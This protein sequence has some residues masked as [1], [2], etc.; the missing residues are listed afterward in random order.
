[1]ETETPEECPECESD[2]LV[3]EGRRIDGVLS[4]A[5]VCMACS[6]YAVQEIASL[7]GG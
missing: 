4:R 7:L 5:L 3:L 1:V 2:Q 6:W